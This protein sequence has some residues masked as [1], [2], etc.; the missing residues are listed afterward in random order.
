MKAR[1]RARSRRGRPSSR[2]AYVEKRRSATTSSSAKS[3]REEI[4]HPR[5]RTSRTSSKRERPRSRRDGEPRLHR[6]ASSRCSPC[7]RPARRSRPVSTRT[8]PAISP[9]MRYFYA[10]NKLRHPVLQLHAEPDERPGARTSTP[11]EQATRS[12]GWT[13]RPGRRCSRRRSPSMFRV[14]RL[15]IEGW[16]STNFLGNN[17]G[18]VL[19]APGSNKT[20]VLSKQPC[21]T[22]SSATTSTT[23]RFT[24]TTTS[25]A[26]TRR[27]P[28]TTS[29]SWALPAMQMQIKVNFLCSG[30]GARGAARHRSGAPAR[31]RQAR[32]RARHPAAALDVLQVAVPRRRARPRCTTSSSRRSSCSTGR[33]THASAKPRVATRT[34]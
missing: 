34:A 32:R 23:T 10:A 13:A 7:T 18:L 14:R 24:S 17:D 11:T 1:A 15:H 21:S 12:R 5:R 8:T 6:D 9:A 22:R 29:T 28:G 26:A 4:A 16:Y 27:R 3:Y 30:L 31:R 2:Q 33:A 25:P 19:D 20:K